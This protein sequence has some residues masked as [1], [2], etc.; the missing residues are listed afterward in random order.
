MAGLD[1][2]IRILLAAIKQDVD[3]RHKAGHNEWLD[4]FVFTSGQPPL[5][6]GRNASSPGT[7][8]IRL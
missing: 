8:A 4:Q 3:A 7:V 5:S 1:P 2:A 6:S